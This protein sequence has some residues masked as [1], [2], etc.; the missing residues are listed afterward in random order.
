MTK[1]INRSISL[2]DELPHIET[3]A[4]VVRSDYWSGVDTLN[5]KTTFLNEDDDVVL[6]L[7][8]DGQALL[9]LRDG[10]MRVKKVM[11]WTLQKGDVLQTNYSDREL[12]QIIDAII[13]TKRGVF[14]IR[15]WKPQ[16]FLVENLGW[17]EVYRDGCT[18][19]IAKGIGAC[20]AGAVL[21]LKYSD[22]TTR[23]CSVRLDGSLC[24]APQ[25][26]TQDGIDVT[27]KIVVG[28]YGT[29]FDVRQQKWVKPEVVIANDVVGYYKSAWQNGINQGEILKLRVKKIEN[30]VLTVFRDVLR[31]RLG[32]AAR[33]L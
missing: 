8:E 18:V 13:G 12:C 28:L 1:K 17:D 30:D 11:P 26:V 4:A 27:E 22:G 2:S 9:Q 3:T 19:V 14:T 32:D 10:K 5:F 6:N 29:C 24:L 16:P 20:I 23:V 31:V 25:F 15:D 33:N 7:L 21:P